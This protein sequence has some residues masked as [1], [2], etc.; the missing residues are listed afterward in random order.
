M[1]RKQVVSGTN[2]RLGIPSGSRNCVK[3]V[4]LDILEAEKHIKKYNAK[5]GVSRRG[6]KKLITEGSEEE[7]IILKCAAADL[8]SSQIAVAVNHYHASKNPAKAAISW[9]TVA[10][11]LTNCDLIVRQLRRSRKTGSF[12][13]GCRWAQAR[14]AQCEQLL[15]Q[16]SL[17]WIPP[18]EL[19]RREIALLPNGDSFPPP[20]RLHGIDFWDE[21]HKKCVLGVLEKFETSVSK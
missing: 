18:D 21:H 10:S 11:Y 16:L 14:K 8:S 9:S 17:G 15:F 6:R 2:D 20:L 12:I 4:L 13:P 1:A 3:K 7:A 19:Q 5:S